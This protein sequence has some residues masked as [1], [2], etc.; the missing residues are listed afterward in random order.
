MR[1]NDIHLLALSYVKSTFDTSSSVCRPSLELNIKK[2]TYIRFFNNDRYLHPVLR[3]IDGWTSICS[4]LSKAIPSKANQF[5][6]RY[7]YY[8]KCFSCPP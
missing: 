2:I 1:A 7:K 8:F 5:I 4:T 3:D 6:K